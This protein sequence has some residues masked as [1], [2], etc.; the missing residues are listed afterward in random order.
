MSRLGRSRPGRLTTTKASSQI[1]T[2]EED[3]IVAVVSGE[4]QGAVSILR[5][6]GSDA[7]GIAGKVFRQAGCKGSEWNPKSHR[8]YY[9]KAVGSDGSTIDE[10]SPSMA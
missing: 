6:S 4:M 5:L 10:V 7:I 8:V 9:G 2:G 1:A 3:T